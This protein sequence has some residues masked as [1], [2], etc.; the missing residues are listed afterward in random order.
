MSLSSVLSLE[1]IGSVG[2]LWLDRAEKYNAL[3]SEVWEAIPDAL[4]Q[5]VADEA[6]KAV[7]LAGRGKHFCVGIDLIASGSKPLPLGSCSLSGH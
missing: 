4:D 3:S 5:F 7:V 1:K 2:V 6:I